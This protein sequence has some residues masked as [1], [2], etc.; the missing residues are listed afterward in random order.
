MVKVMLGIWSLTVAEEVEW[1]ELVVRE[2]EL[3]KATTSSTR[4]N[5]MAAV[6]GIEETGLQRDEEIADVQGIS[7]REVASRNVFG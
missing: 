5:M 4:A 1:V 2:T 3:I 6:G 7:V